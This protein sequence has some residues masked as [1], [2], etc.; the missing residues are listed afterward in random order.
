MSMLTHREPTY[1]NTGIEIIW[2]LGKNEPCKDYLLMF[3]LVQQMEDWQFMHNITLKCKAKPPPVILGIPFY[4]TS[5]SSLDKLSKPK[6][7][8]PKAIPN[9]KKRSPYYRP[10]RIPFHIN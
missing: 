1:K 3:S 2:G 5:Y 10:K 9:S 4:E 6:M 7:R 8:T